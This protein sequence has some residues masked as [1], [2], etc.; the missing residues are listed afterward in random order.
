MPDAKRNPSPQPSDAA[1]PLTLAG[2]DDE[3]LGLLYDQVRAIAGK[4]R[5]SGFRHDSLATTELANET[6]LKVFSKLIDKPFD[7]QQHLVNTIAKVM[8]HLLCERFWRRKARRERAVIT[9]LEYEPHDDRESEIESDWLLDF[10]EQLEVLEERRSRAAEVARLR[11]YFSMTIQEIA[12]TLECSKASAQREFA[13][14]RAFLKRK[15]YDG[16]PVA[17][18]N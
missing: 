18:F 5:R 7:S 15:G 9:Q 16:E 10:T 4:F 11:V 6:L 17:F 1:E 2:L 12:D 13:F 8:Y 14:V 3:A